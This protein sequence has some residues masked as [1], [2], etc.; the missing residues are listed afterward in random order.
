MADDKPEVNLEISSGFFRIS[1]DTVIYNL[2][3]LGGGGLP[4]VE[5]IVERER[6]DDAAAVGTAVLERL[7]GEVTTLA[8]Q[9]LADEMGTVVAQCRTEL[10]EVADLLAA[11]PGGAGSAAST[12]GERVAGL[13]ERLRSVLAL[14]D[15]QAGDPA[16]AASSPE[17]AAPATRQRYAFDLDVVF[18]TLYELCTNEQVKTHITT[19][20]EN[21]DTYFDR[22]AFLEA[23]NAA[24]A[25]LEPDADNFFNVPMS[26]LLAA[27]LAG[28]REKP[29]RN[30]LKK[31]DASQ[32]S[33]F[34]EQFLPLEVPPMEEVAVA[35][36]AAE[37]ETVPSEPETGGD[38]A[39]RL[40]PALAELGAEI[41]AVAGEL[42][43]AGPEPEAGATAELADRLRQIEAR[44]AT[45]MES[46]AAATVGR[47][48]AALALALD[49]AIRQA[50]AGRDPD[51]AFAEALADAADR[52]AA[53]DPAAVA[54]L[55]ASR[56]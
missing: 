33:I 42:A 44:L 34:L 39:D 47:R 1:T 22:E 21:R 53:A 10:A 40:R 12:V 46:A 45:A 30:L 49:A 50:A 36:P 17:P 26:D 38:V 13:S 15:E 54:S 6:R 19:A 48:L 24:V 35:A 7:A 56:A 5:K 55:L 28:C 8:R 31:M 23:I 29:I 32:S 37:P 11:A 51:A 43:T 3:V 41:E 20:R 25:D 27:L 16:P 18:Q 9:V 2:T 4:V 14:L 52:V